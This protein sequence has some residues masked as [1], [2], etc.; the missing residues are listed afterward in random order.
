METKWWFFN[1]RS[2]PGVVFYLATRSRPSDMMVTETNAMKKT[3]MGHSPGF[4]AVTAL[5]TSALA[6]KTAGNN[7]G[8]PRV[9]RKSPVGRLTHRIHGTGIFTYIWLILMVNVGIY[10][11]HG[12]YGLYIDLYKHKSSES[13]FESKKP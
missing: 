7:L 9:D 2:S 12:S 11:I 13:R 4:P 1:P 5:I 8:V 10:T 6:P 3:M